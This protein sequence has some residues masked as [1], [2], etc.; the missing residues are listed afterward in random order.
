MKT[1]LFKGAHRLSC[2]LGPRVKQRLHR[3]LGQ[4][5]LQF[6]EDL[7]GK[8]WVTMACCEQ[9]RLQPYCLQKGKQKEKVENYDSDKGTRKTPRK[10]AK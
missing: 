3:N 1:P 6:L 9:E 2:A 4:T 5:C 7:L 10:T 8:Q